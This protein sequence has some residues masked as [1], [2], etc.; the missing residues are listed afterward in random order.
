MTHFADRL[1]A[2]IRAKGNALCVGLDP[3]WES[4]PQEVRGRQPDTHRDLAVGKAKL[5]PVA[6]AGKRFR[7]HVAFLRHAPIAA[8]R[9]ASV[10][11]AHGR[12]ARRRATV[13][14]VATADAAPP[15]EGWRS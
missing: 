13:R 15:S 11:I 6:C 12:R 7:S 2:A 4:L 5:D 9:R 8:A 1:A 3:R 10:N 14:M